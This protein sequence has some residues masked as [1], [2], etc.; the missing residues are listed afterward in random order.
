MAG[1]WGGAGRGVEVPQQL[2]A[3]RFKVEGPGLEG[4]RL[5]EAGHI[6]DLRGVGVTA[7]QQHLLRVRQPQQRVAGPRG[8]RQGRLHLL[9]ASGHHVEGPGVGQ[10]LVQL[11]A[12]EQDGLLVHGV[13]DKPE[14][15]RWGG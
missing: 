6:P 13:V 4:E 12:A 15:A 11:V 3:V 8:R 10:E 9:P 14:L 1:P 2:P 5:V 7:Q